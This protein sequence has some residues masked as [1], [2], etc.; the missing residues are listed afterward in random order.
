MSRPYVAGFDIDGVIGDFV[1]SFREVVLRAYSTELSEEDIRG[2]DLFLALG[3]GKAEALGLIRQTLEHPGYALYPGASKGLEQLVREG[4]EVH[5]VTARWNGD[6]K[7]GELTERWLASRGLRNGTHY[8]RID[9]VHE[10]AKHGV[11]ASLDSFVDDNLVELLEMAD[12][13]K[14]IRTLIVFDHPWNRTIDIH[15]RL[16]R[17]AN[18]PALVELLGVEAQRMLKSQAPSPA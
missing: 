14:D 1:T 7:A 3:V 13:R 4:I 9:A 8:H 15:G 17:V 6:P 10:G 16:R 18:W 12:R 11:T 2:H 5:I